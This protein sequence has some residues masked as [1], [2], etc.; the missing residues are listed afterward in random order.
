MTEE[1]VRRKYCNCT[2]KL[3][4]SAIDGKVVLICSVSIAAIMIAGVLNSPEVS[5]LG[6]PVQSALVL[7]AECGVIMLLMVLDI[8]SFQEYENGFDLHRAEKC[9]SG[10]SSA[11]HLWCRGREIQ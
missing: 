11:N 6:Q 1:A 4:Y 9:T 5:A 10:L 8:Q 3:D 7:S 2:G